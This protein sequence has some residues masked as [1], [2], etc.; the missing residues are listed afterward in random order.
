MK[1]LA[2]IAQKSGAEEKTIKR[3]LGANTARMFWKSFKKMFWKSR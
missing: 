3:I 2:E 1:L